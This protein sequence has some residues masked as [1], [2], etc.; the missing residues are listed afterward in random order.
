MVEWVPKLFERDLLSGDWMYKHV[1]MRP[2]DPMN[3]LVQYEY[4]YKI[5]TWTKHKTPI[6]RTLSITSLEQKSDLFQGKLHC[7]SHIQR[8]SV[9]RLRMVGEESESSNPDQEHRHE[10]DSSEPGKHPRVQ[11]STSSNRNRLTEEALTTALEPLL[12]LQ[13]DTNIVMKSLQRNVVHLTQRLE[14]QQEGFLNQNRDWIVLAVILLFQVIL[15]W[16]LR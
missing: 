2:W 9:K 7:S 16:L 6:V 1:D 15:Q 10:S 13:R 4:D 5:Q 11:R 3:D 12:E 8:N 14:L